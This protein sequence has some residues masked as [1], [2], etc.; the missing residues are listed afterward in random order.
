M[1]RLVPMLFLCHILSGLASWAHAE[2]FT[3]GNLFV[4]SF[5]TDNIFEFDLQ[6]TKLR[7]FGEAG[8][9]PGGTAFGPHGHLFVASIKKGTLVEFAP[10][11]A[12]VR[13]VP[14]V[15][16]TGLR[17]LIWGPNGNL[18]V[19]VATANAVFELDRQSLKKL[20]ELS[21]SGLV[22]PGG[23]AFGP[24]S[25]LFVT[26]IDSGNVVEFD[27]DGA[28]AGE[29][30]VVR[31]GRDLL[32]ALTIDSQGTLFVSAF[33]L[34]RV[35]VFTLPQTAVSRWIGE[36]SSLDGPGG[37]AVGPNGNLFVG[38]INTGTVLEFDPAGKAV[39]AITAPGLD[40][41]FVLFA[42]TR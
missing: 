16:N 34:D 8:L 25:H 18:F 6:G 29:I 20:R 17:G 10:S 5:Q 22:S 28:K 26:G 12:K 32:R 1:K 39:R 24:R 33:A 9:G 14:V 23:V 40:P 7:E 11:G 15:R 30:S 31:G 38:S 13:E 27:A 2:T 21:S 35:A 19:A 36:G 42:P 3:P 37:I 41:R 4:A